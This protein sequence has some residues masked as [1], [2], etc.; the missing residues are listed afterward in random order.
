MKLS[1]YPGWGVIAGL[2]LLTLTGCGEPEPNVASGVVTMEGTPIETGE[3]LFMPADGKGSVGAGPITNGQFSFEC[4]PGDK[5]VKITATREQG[6]AA[7]G[8]PNWVSFIPKKYNE[9]TTLTAKV[10]DGGE[11]KFTFDLDKK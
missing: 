10:V 3:I 7:D 11:N 4:Q 2:L 1:F 6:K 8:L 9:K 5:L